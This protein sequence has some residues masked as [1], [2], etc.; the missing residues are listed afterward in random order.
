MPIKA[1]LWF[2]VSNILQK[3][4]QFLTVPILTRIMPAEAYGEYSV[5]LSWYQIISIF[6]TLKMWNYAINNGMIKYEN[7]RNGYVSSLQ[8]LST[9][10][11]VGFFL[12]YLPFSGLWEKATSLSFMAMTIMFIE[13]LL[14]PSY[15]YWCAKER[16][17]YRYKGVV[18]ISVA[19][20]AL[21]PIV[22][23]PLVLVTKDKGMSAIIGRTITSA[24]IF[25]I[26]AVIIAKKGKKFYKK[27]YWS[28][29]LRFNLPL[30]PHFLSTMIL[31]QSDRIMISNISGVGKAGIYSVAYSASMMMQIISSAIL[32]SFI[33]YTYKS[34]K[35]KSLEGIKQNGNYLLA[36][37]AIVNLGL[38][39]IAPEAIRFLGPSEY[40]EA[41]YI[42][43][44]VAIS[45]IFMFLFNLFVN[46]EYYF[47]KTKFVAAAS[48]GSAI[49]NIILNLICIPRFGYIAAGYTTLICYILYSLGHYF[50]MRLVCRKYL[51]GYKVYDTKTILIITILSLVITFILLGLYDYIIIRYLIILLVLTICFINRKK[52]VGHFKMLK[53]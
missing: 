41:I 43:P 11:T 19:V 14:M 20:T 44:P 12:L 9:I 38:I 28:F 18:I 6:V 8:G 15:E 30:L 17:E 46:I 42:I 39:C 27:E 13:L 16:F 49:L 51:N 47:E 1:S 35:D 21:I 5:F 36:F 29:A 52:L 10:I 2:T 31:Q 24:V 34:I 33:P 7:D 4:I 50:F 48:I 26:P 53:G 23:I 32:A 40:R 37:V 45:V 25:L 22:S 3:G